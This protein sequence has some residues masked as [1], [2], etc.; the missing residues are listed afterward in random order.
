MA[1]KLAIGVAFIL[2]TLLSLHKPFPVLINWMLLCLEL[3]L[4]YLLTVMAAGVASGWQRAADMR[5]LADSLAK[6]RSVT[7]PGTIVAAEAAGLVSLPPA[8]WF[9]HVS[10]NDPF[11]SSAVQTYLRSLGSAYAELV[12]ILSKQSDSAAAALRYHARKQLLTTYLDAATL[13]LNAIA[14]LGYGVFPITYFIPQATVTGWAPSWPGHD[15]AQFW[16]NLAG[17][18]AWT[19][20][21]VLLL[22]VPVAINLALGAAPSSK[23]KNE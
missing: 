20:E 14:F 19:I 23:A 10:A 17:D 8:P 4:T 22:V 7:H 18:M 5:R 6:E 11:G 16:G 3:A 1:C 9:D 13:A 2:L 15:S 21:A 12:A